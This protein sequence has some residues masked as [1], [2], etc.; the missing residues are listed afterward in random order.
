[1]T[2]AE[3]D[4]LL[5]ALEADHAR[6]NV[7]AADRALLD[8]AVTLTLRPGDVG[9]ADVAALREHGFEDLAIHDL[10]AVVAYYAFVNR[11]ADGLGVELEGADGEP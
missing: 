3:Q 2:G 9:A 7:S 10:C 5:A 8:Y 4:D 11:I 1:M 6:A